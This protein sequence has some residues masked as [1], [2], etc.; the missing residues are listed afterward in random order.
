MATATDEEMDAAP[1]PEDNEDAD[2]PVGENDTEDDGGQEEAD[3]IE[4]DGTP[5]PSPRINFFQ[6]FSTDASS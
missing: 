6:N 2:S 5:G 4:C 3:G 1:P